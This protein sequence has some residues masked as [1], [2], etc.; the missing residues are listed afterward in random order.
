LQSREDDAPYLTE[1]QMQPVDIVNMRI[2][3]M[4]A[5]ALNTNLVA[6]AYVCCDLRTLLKYV[7]SRVVRVW[8]LGH[9]SKPK[10]LHRAGYQTTVLDAIT[11]HAINISPQKSRIQSV[12]RMGGRILMHLQ[13]LLRLSVPENVKCMRATLLAA[14]TVRVTHCQMMTRMSPSTRLAW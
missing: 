1:L 5:P 3:S 11:V 10:K 12:S 7:R 6:S 2:R 8:P 13:S 4:I 14:S 9:C